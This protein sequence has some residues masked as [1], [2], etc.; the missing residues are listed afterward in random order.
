MS[1]PPRT[2]MSGKFKKF[3]SGVRCPCHGI[4]AGTPW[5]LDR[6]TPNLLCVGKPLRVGLVLTC[7]CLILSTDSNSKGLFDT[8]QIWVDRIKS[9][10]C[11]GMYTVTMELDLVFFVA[12]SEIS[13]RRTSVLFS[14]HFLNPVI[15]IRSIVPMK[16]SES[17]SDVEIWAHW[18]DTT[19]KLLID[20]V[21]KSGFW[22]EHDSWVPVKKVLYWWSSN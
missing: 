9:P 7:F 12:T 22:D 6:H 8:Q 19:G 15:R 3:P 16:G 14:D 4:H 20:G 18:H 5:W 10:R 1:L 11:H 2:K 13:G 17:L 21:E